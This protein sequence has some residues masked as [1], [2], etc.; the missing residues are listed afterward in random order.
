MP[1]FFIRRWKLLLLLL[2]L[3]M[4]SMGVIYFLMKAP[5]G[6]E[7]SNL[8]ARIVKKKIS[9]TSFDWKAEV[10]LFA[11]NNAGDGASDSGI[12]GAAS[13]INVKLTDP[14]G[15]AVDAQGNLYVSDAADNN[16]IR[17]ISVD[18]QVSTVA[19][20]SEGFADGQGTL[21][22]FNSPSGM[23]IDSAGNLL[24]A[25]TGNHAIR[26]ISP[27][28]LVSTLAGNGKPGARDGAAAKAQF[29][30]PIGIAV[31]KTGNV[32]VADTYNDSIRKISPDGQVTT[33]AGG[34]QAGYQDGAALSALFDTPTGIAIDTKGD[35]LIADS[36]NDVL[37]RLSKEGVVT[38]IVRADSDENKPLMRRPYSVA[39][40]PDNFAYVGEAGNGRI[41]QISPEGKMRGLTGIDIDFQVGDERSLRFS[42]PTGIALDAKG[43]VFVSDSARQL[44]AKISPHIAI[45]GKSNSPAAA[46][47][48][49][50]ITPLAIKKLPWPVKPQQS[51]HEVVGTMGEVRG[52]YDGESRDHFHA[53]LDVQANMGTLVYAIIDEKVRSP[54]NTWSYEGLSEGIKLDSMAY[55]HIRVG[56][57]MKNVLL[58]DTKF[59]VLNDAEGK[60]AA[61]RVRRGTRFT[62]GEALGSINRM[63]HVHLEHSQA[64]LKTNPLALSFPGLIDTV[65][66]K[67]EEISI[68]DQTGQSLKQK[69]NTRLLLSRQTDYTIVVDAYDQVDGNAKRRR[70]G[71][72]KLGY[73]VLHADGSPVAGDENPRFNIEFNALPPDRE[74]VQLA[75][76]EDSGITVHGS[77][78]T[79]FL[80]VATNSVRDG[81]AR[82]GV[83]NLS[84]LAAGDYILR[85]HALDF[86]GNEAMQN[87]DL[88]F[89]LE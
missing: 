26:K 72:Y 39:I 50:T 59:Q 16:L 84:Q 55:I 86:S 17:K 13:S 29:N 67:I 15:I 61:M 46:T 83:W 22:A 18:G 34:S 76:A 64:G 57:S 54:L 45:A 74:S 58:D 63:F 30:G 38:T 5:P 19:G 88:P 32:F 78:K 41:I 65:A 43:A 7:P 87:R 44:I 1:R 82:K 66:P 10:T 8:L 60:P 81:H 35:L 56:R 24:V 6:T 12:D 9:G 69:K 25:D 80:Y 14:Y 42:Q 48:A 68:L 89:R 28:G 52:N 36:K 21:A 51:A 23:A 2:L 27:A 85:I 71:I 33:I 70:L 75:Y 73:Q 62:T 47:V 3:S 49:Q 31:D 77:K 40:T 11:G 79:R 4:G 20:S 37:R 53:G